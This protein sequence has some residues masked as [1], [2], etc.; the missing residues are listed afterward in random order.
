MTEKLHVRHLYRSVCGN[1]LNMSRVLNDQCFN[2][3]ISKQVLSSIQFTITQKIEKKSQYTIDYLYTE[4]K[5][6]RKHI[7]SLDKA[8][9]T[10]HDMSLPLQL[11]INECNGSIQVVESSLKFRSRKLLK[12]SR[13]DLVPQAIFEEHSE[14]ISSPVDPA[15]YCPLLYAPCDS[16]SEESEPEGPEEIKT[17]DIGDSGDDLTDGILA[18]DGVR[19]LLNMVREEVKDIQFLD[20]RDGLLKFL[21]GRRAYLKR[22]LQYF[23][24]MVLFPRV[25]YGRYQVR[26]IFEGTWIDPREFTVNVKKKERRGYFNNSSYFLRSLQEATQ[27]ISDTLVEVMDFARAVGSL[28]VVNNDYHLLLT[29]YTKVLD[30]VAAVK[31]GK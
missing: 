20:L 25:G 21:D 19:F 5:R 30:A 27:D 12:R 6:V 11:T 17:S 28:K 4:Q 13:G 24:N 18:V 15:I 14:M 22:R 1:H 8:I 2:S 26:I 7:S 29:L 3:S 9:D 31:D 23:V 10:L 16:S